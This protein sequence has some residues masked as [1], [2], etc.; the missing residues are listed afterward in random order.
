MNQ[1]LPFKLTAAYYSQADILQL[2]SL[3]DED[4]FTVS[5]LENF[6]VSAQELLDKLQ[7]ILGR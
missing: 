5:V 4:N 7:S 3:N 6:I 1:I 2:L